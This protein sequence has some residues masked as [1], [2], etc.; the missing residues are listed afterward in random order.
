MGSGSPGPVHAGHELV[1]LALEILHDPEP[2]SVSRCKLERPANLSAPAV[3]H[4][5]EFPCEE[6]R[7]AGVLFLSVLGRKDPVRK[8]M[9][10]LAIWLNLACR[11]IPFCKSYLCA[12]CHLNIVILMHCTKL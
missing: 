10:D 6:I 2:S 8:V 3:R 4:R 5:M 1:G 7:A 11:D 12:L 9:I